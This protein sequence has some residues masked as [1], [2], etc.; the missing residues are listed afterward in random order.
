MSQYLVEEVPLMNEHYSI[1]LFLHVY[2]ENRLIVFV[3]RGY[4]LII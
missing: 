2:H 1:E 4:K 3:L